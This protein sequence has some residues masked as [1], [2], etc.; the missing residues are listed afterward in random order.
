MS[1]HKGTEPSHASAPSAL[2]A[3]GCVGC[4]GGDPKATTIEKAHVHPRNPELWGK[5]GKVRF[6]GNPERTYTLLNRE[7]P[8]FIRFINPGDLRVVHETCGSKGCHGEVEPTSGNIVLAVKKSMMTHG[9]FLYGAALYNNGAIPLKDAVVG[10]SYSAADLKRIHN[11]HSLPQRVQG[12]FF[13]EEKK[14]WRLPTREETLNFGWLP[15]LDPLPRWEIAQTGNVFRVFERGGLKKAEIGNP[16]RDEEP[17]RPD[18]KLSNRGF[19]TLLRTDPVVLGAQKT[20]LF[21]P[22][23]NFLGT[24][25]QPGDYRS[26]G[27]SACHNVYANDPDPFHSAHFAKYGKKGTGSTKDEAMQDAVKRGERGHPVTHQMTNEIP[28]SQCIT[29]H[30]HPGTNMLA[31]YLGFTWWDNET[32]GDGMYSAKPGEHSPRTRSLIQDRNPEGAALRGKWGDV[33]WLEEELPKLNASRKHTQFAEFNGHGWIFRGVYKRDRKGNLLDKDGK[34]LPPS[35]ESYKKNPPE[36]NHPLEPGLAVHL[37]DI[38]LERGMHCVDCHYRQDNHGTTKL[39][40]EP[41]AAIEVTCQDCHG[42][43]EKAADPTNEEA[44]TSGPAGPNKF[45]RYML[46]SVAG[47]PVIRFEKADDGTLTQNSAVTPDL[48]WEVPQ[49]IDTIT[50]GHKRYNARSARAK[51]M[52]RDNKTWGKVD[53]VEHLAHGPDKVTCYTCHSSWTTACFGCH[54]SMSANQKKPQLHFE[55]MPS[56]NW[57]S[58]NFQTLRDDVY[59]LGKEGSI[60]A[61][62]GPDGKPKPRTVPVRSSCAVLVSSQNQNR[63]WIYQQQQTVS[64]EG[65]SGTAFSTYVPHTVRDKET[66]ACSDCH[67]SEKNDNNAWLANLMLLGSKSVNFLGRFAYVGTGHGFE[68]VQ[69]TELDEPQAVIGSYL[70]KLAYPREHGRHVARGR[71][72]KT[73]HTHHSRTRSLQLRGEYL[74]SAEGA[75]GLWI[76]DVANIHNKGFSERIVTAPVSP[77]GQR[78]FVPTRD[79]TDVA[80]PSTMTIDPGRTQ[81]PENQEQKIH[82]LYGYLYVTDKHEGLIVV[83][84]ATLFDGNPTNNFLKRAATWNPNGVLSG[85][86]SIRIAGSYAYITCDRGLAIVSIDDPRHPKLVREIGAP[87]LNGPVSVAVQFRYAFVCDRDGLK[88]VDVTRPEEARVVPGAVIPLKQANDV[89]VSR[90]YAYVAAGSDGLLIVDVENPEQ[91]KVESRFDAG[92]TLNDAHAVAVGMTNNSTYAYVA[93]GHNG[94]RVVQITSPDTTPGIYGYSPRPT[95]TLIATF[96]TEEPAVA[97][98]EGQDRDRA[99]DES[100]NQ[101]SVFGRRGARPLNL[102]ERQ[103]MMYLNEGKGPMFKVTDDPGQPPAGTAAAPIRAELMALGSILGLALFRRRRARS[104]PL[105]KLP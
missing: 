40:A 58:Y 89:Y 96:P 4:H 19:G 17:G 103:R 99:V 11:P 75:D 61:P 92:G 25:D 65:L 15:F 56:R 35:A 32:D 34:V 37:R 88:V 72:L 39:Y 24:N 104:L 46:M 85:A 49:V 94:L 77:L 7:D 8:R 18:V 71:R 30:M 29:C 83:G 47:N 2:N 95:P 21:D 74:Y 62:R 51:T 50:P 63:E 79:A 5:N 1:C 90:T 10:E 84:A 69:V 98:S 102:E 67:L 54:L 105:P 68:A 41:R 87:A 53:S 82:P 81:R 73:S 64:A 76:Y 9:G 55:G 33:K 57:T 70:H 42:T 38:H 22:T 14:E 20:R 23:L 16:L 66:K 12:T 101:L 44:K 27:C 45:E 6:S 59:M 93:D 78:F 48:K 97:I 26:G 80:A 86:S 31:S 13:D 3:F 43:V 36:P 91:P 28:T 100:G 60:T 52:H